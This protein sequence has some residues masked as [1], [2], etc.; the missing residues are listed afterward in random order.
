MQKSMKKIVAFL[1]AFVVAVSVITTGSLT[2]EA[3]SV[4]TVTYRVHV[5]KDGWKQ[6]WVKNGKSAGTTGEA[7]DWKQL[8]L[9]SKVTRILA[10]S[11]KPTFSQKVGKRTSQ[12]MV[13]RVVPLV[14]QRDWRQS[15]SN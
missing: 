14:L 2:S 11:T 6:G 8:R 10:L 4:P 9:R 15:R 3:A 5:Q 7:R 13:V 12:Q 1:L